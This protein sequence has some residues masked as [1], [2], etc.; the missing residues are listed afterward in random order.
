MYGVVIWSDR[1]ADRAVIWCEDHGDLAY[2]RGDRDGAA[3]DRA[4][5]MEAGDLVQFDVA[6]GREMRLA[7]RPRLVVQDSHPT[8][9]GDLRRAG[10]GAGGLPD[11]RS[12][13]PRSADTPPPSANVVAFETHRCVRSA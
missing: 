13:L 8:L 3:A 2:Y 4:E 9:A 5:T 12:D 1:S 6:P 11:T 7:R 10:A